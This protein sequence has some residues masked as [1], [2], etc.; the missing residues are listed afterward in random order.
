MVLSVCISSEKRPNCTPD[1]TRQS[2]FFTEI[3]RTSFTADLPSPRKIPL[4]SMWIHKRGI[5]SLVVISALF[6]SYRKISGGAFRP[7]PPPPRSGEVGEWYHTWNTMKPET[8]STMQLAPL[9]LSSMHYCLRS[10]VPCERL[11][12]KKETY[13]NNQEVLDDSVRW[14]AA[15]DDC[16]TS[17]L[18]AF[19]TC[20]IEARLSLFTLPS[21]LLQRMTSEGHKSTHFRSQADVPHSDPGKHA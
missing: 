21:T 6:F 3:G 20:W 18:T 5:Q 7:P 14:T 11:A 16:F 2:L 13:P 12:L 8:R 4:V 10:D 1:V 9:S 17:S 19:F 15:T